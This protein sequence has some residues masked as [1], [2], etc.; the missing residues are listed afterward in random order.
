MD[1]MVG[2]FSPAVY[3]SGFIVTGDAGPRQ[4]QVETKHHKLGLHACGICDSSC[5]LI[6]LSSGIILNF[7]L[8][9]I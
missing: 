9:N 5:I 3:P 1:L 2:S 6:I 7:K 4:A 8:A